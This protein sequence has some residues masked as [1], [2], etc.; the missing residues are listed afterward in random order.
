M[1]FW[2]CDKHETAG[3]ITKRD[4]WDKLFSPLLDCEIRIVSNDNAHAL[5]W[6]RME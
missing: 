1:A 6:K 3:K 4:D 5:G 2:I